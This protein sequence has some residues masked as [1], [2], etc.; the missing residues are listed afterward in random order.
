MDWMRLLAIM[1]DW[2]GITL[3][4][5]PHLPDCNGQ[6]HSC[7]STAQ[8]HCTVSAAPPHPCRILSPQAGSRQGLW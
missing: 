8:L 5:D 7:Q 3:L 2:H 4:Q 6:A 1:S